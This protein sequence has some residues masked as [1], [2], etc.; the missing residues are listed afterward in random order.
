MTGCVV[1]VVSRLCPEV[2]Y[3]ILHYASL[4][5]KILHVHHAVISATLLY[6]YIHA[7]LC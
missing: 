4:H 1:N 5:C 7:N 3:K 6:A 2:C